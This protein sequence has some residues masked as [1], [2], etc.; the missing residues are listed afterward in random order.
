M[1]PPGSH[2]A[3][4]QQQIVIG[5][6]LEIQIAPIAPAGETLPDE[7]TQLLF[8]HPETLTTIH[9]DVQC[10]KSIDTSHYP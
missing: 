10:S 6:I 8:G 5:R 1:I 7:R 9:S 2:H 4:A 3:I